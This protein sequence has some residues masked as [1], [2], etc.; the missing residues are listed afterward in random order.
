[1]G[2]GVT[3][4]GDGLGKEL[5][6]ARSFLALPRCTLLELPLVSLS[7][8]SA[9][10]S[11]TARACSL[12]PLRTI[13]IACTVVAAA[14]IVAAVSSTSGFLPLVS[15]SSEVV[16][17]APRK[18]RRSTCSPSPQASSKVS[19]G[20][21]ELDRGAGAVGVGA[22]AHHE[23][24]GVGP[25]DVAERDVDAAVAGHARRLADDGLDADAG[26]GLHVDAGV[27]RVD[28]LEAEHLALEELRDLGR[29]AHVVELPARELGDG[30]HQRLVVVGG[31]ARAR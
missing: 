2:E 11:S 1:M 12:S 21:E 8:R 18:T 6:R 28:L 16:A 3:A 13:S 26:A 30:A 23:I 19:T 29:L 17:L 15:S 5:R 4:A 25:A 24:A 31:R 22:D 9:A 10:W 7:A 27:A 14:C 20:V